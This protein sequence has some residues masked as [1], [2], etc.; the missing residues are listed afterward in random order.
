[1]E[2]SVVEGVLTQSLVVMLLYA[3]HQTYQTKWFQSTE[4]HINI[5]QVWN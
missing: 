4:E 2:A 1:M 5:A 3:T